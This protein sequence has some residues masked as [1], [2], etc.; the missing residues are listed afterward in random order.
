[1]SLMQSDAR[2]SWAPWLSRSNDSWRATP[3]Q[4]AVKY[5][6]SSATSRPASR[7]MRRTSRGIPFGGGSLES[8]QLLRPGLMELPRPSV[9]EV[10]LGV[11]HR[12]TCREAGQQLY[13]SVRVEHG[14]SQH[15]AMLEGFIAFVEP[16]T[17]RLYG[18]RTSPALPWPAGPR[19]A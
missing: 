8:N 18:A 3:C 10:G 17:R 7:S 19:A 15:G 4:E 6:S 2:M 9:L 11:E 16:V 14:L 12:T 5:F 13:H 1:M